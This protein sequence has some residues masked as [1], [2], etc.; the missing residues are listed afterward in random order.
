[1][2][3][4]RKCLAVQCYVGYKVCVPEPKLA[5]AK[6]VGDDAWQLCGSGK[7]RQGSP[8]GLPFC[9]P[10]EPLIGGCHSDATRPSRIKDWLCRSSQWTARLRV[11]RRHPIQAMAS[12]KTNTK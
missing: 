12:T 5:Q 2:A 11:L 6:S 9:F 1:M 4:L 3:K 8:C 10:L 7:T